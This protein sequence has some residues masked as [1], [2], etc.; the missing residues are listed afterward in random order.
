MHDRFPL[1]WKGVGIISYVRHYTLH[2]VWRHYT[3]QQDW[4]SRL[5]ICSYEKRP[6]HVS[7]TNHLNAV[8]RRYCLQLPSRL[9]VIIF[10]ISR[11]LEIVVLLLTQSA[12]CSSE[13]SGY[14]QRNR[15]CTE[16]DYT[17]VMLMTSLWRHTISQW[18]L[19]LSHCHCSQLV[20]YCHSFSVIVSVTATRQQS[21][22]SIWH[23]VTLWQVYD[24]F[25]P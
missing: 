3:L 2:Q 9:E 6:N 24:T 13:Q 14:G 19:L 12:F 21:L 10:L 15:Q 8:S 16:R 17:D 4:S 20:N 25:L 1:S 18:C 5:S 22:L 7:K 11:L 23:T